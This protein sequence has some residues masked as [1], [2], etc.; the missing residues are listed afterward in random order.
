MNSNLDVWSIQEDGSEIYTALDQIKSGLSIIYD[1]CVSMLSIGRNIIHSRI[2]DTVIYNEES[3][4]LIMIMKDSPA[5]KEDAIKYLTEK[6][7]KF[8]E[9]SFLDQEQK[10]EDDQDIPII[11][12]AREEYVLEDAVKDNVVKGLIDCTYYPVLEGNLN[13]NYINNHFEPESVDGRI[14]KGLIEFPDKLILLINQKDNVDEQGNSRNMTSDRVVDLLK[15][16]SIDPF[17][18]MSKDIEFKRKNKGPRL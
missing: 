12:F 5:T 11:W 3:D 2:F 17:I 18:C 8:V 7:Q 13:F 9:V 15:R 16:Y 6:G 14:F 4:V 10:I 1:N